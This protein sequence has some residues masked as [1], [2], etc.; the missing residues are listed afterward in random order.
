MSSHPSP[1]SKITKRDL[2]KLKPPPSPVEL[3]GDP[4]RGLQPVTYH[5]IHGRLQQ[6][7]TIS[8]KNQKVLQEDEYMEALS[9]IIKRDFF[10]CLDQF[11][12]EKVKWLE[13]RRRKIKLIQSS[14]STQASNTLQDQDNFSFAQTDLNKLN[15]SENQQKINNL[16]S[17]NWEDGGPTP[18]ICRATTPGM[19]P[20]GSTKFADTPISTPGP[21]N[22]H[23]IDPI[24]SSRPSKRPY[25]SLSLDEFC[26]RYTSEDNSSFSEILNNA[27]RLKRL[28]Y[29]WAFDSSAKHNA[30]LLES[31]LKREHLIM[32]IGKMSTG[33][34]GVGL[35]EG[36]SGKP[37]ERKMIEN[38]ITK[39]E[40][41]A[42]ETTNQQN[43]ITQNDTPSMAQSSHSSPII[44]ENRKSVTAIDLASDP[45]LQ[46]I[47]NTE[48]WPHVTRNALMF[49]PDANVSSHQP[50]QLP[51]FPANPPVILAEPKS[52]NY[53]STRISNDDLL[54]NAVS[55]LKASSGHSTS[56]LS[57]TRSQI[58]NAI[59]GTPYPQPE[60]SS[61]K[62]NGFS[63]VP[64]MP[65][66]N[67]EQ[68]NMSAQLD[69]LMT[70]GEII[71][72]PL[73]VDNLASEEEELVEEGPFK[74][75]KT[76]RREELAIG[77]ARKASKSLREKYGSAS[78]LGIG[79]SS[80]LRN[81]LMAG[82]SREIGNKPE[83]T[84]SIGP[85]TPRRE[86]M[87]SPAA[88][89]LLKKTGSFKGTPSS[90]TPI[91]GS[92]LRSSY[93]GSPNVGTF[94]SK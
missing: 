63:F 37:G 75:P 19:T 43:L 39:E 38:V 15:W 61:P 71:S 56:T 17:K 6:A 5:P 79:R 80:R 91:H 83:S 20:L 49:T 46:P 41:L 12:K 10:P 64:E 33:G 7:P 78:G 92:N 73:R 44:Q 68:L 23:L 27:N 50:A 65:T 34:Q 8:L 53:A 67:P 24:N 77:M 42:I 82:H 35:L 4:A 87:L 57:P 84:S 13:E 16:N 81:N 26:A 62:I 3:Q 25:E 29:S 40:R 54:G 14:K 58:V 55:K 30:R 74:I 52:I 93:S 48:S 1:S 28:K 21:S 60:S 69:Q 18:K 51:P 66:P 47:N 59:N 11:E 36:I 72:T 94:T 76:P 45:R 22:S 2:I 9:N 89:L 31:T 85:K 32:L 86:D 90:T 88:K 70:W